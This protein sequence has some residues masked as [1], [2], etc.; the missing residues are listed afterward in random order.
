[1]DIPF[2]NGDF[3]VR[4]VSLPEGMTHKDKHKE[5]YIIRVF[6]YK[7]LLFFSIRMYVM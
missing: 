4:Y 1:M 6:D 3:P 2:E 7:Y 5:W